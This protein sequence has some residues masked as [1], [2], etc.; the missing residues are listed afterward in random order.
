MATIKYMIKAAVV[1]LVVGMSSCTKYEY[2]DTGVSNG[3]HDCTMW[4]YFYTDPYNWDSTLLLIER[5]GLRSL[6]DGTGKYKQITFFGLTNISIERH[7]FMH[8]KKLKPGDPGYWNGVKDI[9]VAECRDIIEKLVVPVRFMHDDVPMGL[10]TQTNEDGVSV[11]K[12]TGGVAIPC[13][14]GNLFI[15]TEREDFGGVDHAGAWMM[16]IAS[17][18]IDGAKS[19]RVASMDIQTTNGVVHALDYN[20]RFINF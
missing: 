16:F 5:A 20:F 7:I 15:W 2:I 19:E 4:E 10:R 6:F 3:V 18:N 17:R 12:E 1:L 9:P 14:R 13:I 11:V 8:N